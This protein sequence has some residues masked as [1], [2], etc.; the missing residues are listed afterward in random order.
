MIVPRFINK[1]RTLKLF[2]HLNAKIVKDFL[3][4]MKRKFVQCFL[5]IIKTHRTIMKIIV[6]LYEYDGVIVLDNDMHI[7]LFYTLKDEYV[8][9]YLKTTNHIFKKYYNVVTH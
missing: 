6:D 4:S 9:I 1:S 2:P 3:H 8:C 5:K 7:L